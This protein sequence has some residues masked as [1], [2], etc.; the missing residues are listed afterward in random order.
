MIQQYYN[1]YEDY[2]SNGEVKTIPGIILEP[3]SNDKSEIYKKGITRLDKLSQLYYNNPYHGFLILA[4][5]P[6]WGGLEFYIPDGEVLYIP[7]TFSSALTRYNN[8]I[9]KHIELYGE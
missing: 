2:T 3:D 9:K 8:K 5:N 1:R 4:R 7:F 6:Q